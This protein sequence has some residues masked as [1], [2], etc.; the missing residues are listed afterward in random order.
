MVTCLYLLLF[1]L[2]RERLARQV[3][4]LNICLEQYR[5]W[6]APVLFCVLSLANKSFLKGLEN[7]GQCAL[8]AQ[9]NV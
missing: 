6:H 9:N 8:I 3:S 4:E 1:S 2:A 5:S 7:K